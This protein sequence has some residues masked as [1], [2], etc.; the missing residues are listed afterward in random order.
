M[1]RTPRAPWKKAN[2]R[3][4]AGKAPTHLSSAEKS[5]AKRSAKR[6]GRR[7]PNLVDN[8]RVAAKKARKTKTSG[9]KRAATS[10]PRARLS[11]RST[12]RKSSAR[13]SASDR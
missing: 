9:R 12:V 5:A 4:R 1:A 10:S 11:K 8:M 6:A 3:K 7:Y 13:K 2:P